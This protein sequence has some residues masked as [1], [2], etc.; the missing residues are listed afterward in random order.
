[1][2]AL[3]ADLYY[4]SES[5]AAWKIYPLAADTPVLPQLFAITAQAADTAV[6]VRAW[7]PFL[8][9]ATT[10][11]DWM[12]DDEKQTV[13]RYQALKTYIDATLTKVEVYRLGEIE[14]HVFVVGNTENGDTL[15]L[16]TQAVET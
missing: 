14:I 8:Q 5:D 7:Q 16:A 12:S 6:E 10:L 2:A 4:I 3:T 13:A 15:A 11:Q 9:H 1:M